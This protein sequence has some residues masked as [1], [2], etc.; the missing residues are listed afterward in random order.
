[1]Y[2]F[3]FFSVQAEDGILDGHVTGVQT[4]ALPIY[5]WQTDPV[6][7]HSRHRPPQTSTGNTPPEGD[8]SSSQPDSGP[9]PPTP[10]HTQS[11]QPHSPTPNHQTHA[12]PTPAA[13]PAGGTC[14]SML[15]RREGWCG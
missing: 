10:T 6:T 14:I 11:E 3:T 9:S 13:A 12:Q 2:A 7:A 8:P 15:N 5:R 1:M 4:C